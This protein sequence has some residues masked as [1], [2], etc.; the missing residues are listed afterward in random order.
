MNPR[1][2]LTGAS[3]G[4]GRATALQLAE[5]GCALALA[6]RNLERLEGVAADCRRHGVETA[7]VRYDALEAASAEAAVD[8]A[9]ALRGGTPTLVNC[10]GVATFGAFASMPWEKVQEQV[11]ANLLGPMAL[12]HAA[13]PWMLEFGSGLI[14]N[15]SS[16]A[17]EVAFGGA[18]AYS[19]SKGGLRTFSRSLAAEY[20][21]QGIRVSTIQPGAVDTPIWGTGGPPREDM[22]KAEAVAEAIVSVVL[23]PADRSFDEIVLMPPKGIL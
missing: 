8:A 15:V 17:A 16:I 13:L 18:A 23:S 11:T 22:L 6:G 9:R 10:A 20:R 12:C 14:V 7:V 21:R 4:I 19:A 5:S 3:S 2:L 1:I